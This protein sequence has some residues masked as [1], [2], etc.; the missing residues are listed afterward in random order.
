VT[1]PHRDH[2][3][4]RKE[5]DRVSE[6][7]YAALTPDVILDAVET[8]GRR[9][10]GALQALNSYENRVYRV[11]LEDDKPVAAKFY[12]PARWS[13]AAIREE[14]GFALELAAQEIPVVAPL[15]RDGET[16]FTHAG[17]RFALFPWQPG[18]VSE[19]NSREEREVLGRYLGRLHRVGRARRFEHRPALTVESFGRESADYL[20]RNN[21]LPDY[22]AGSY[23]TLADDLLE[24]IANRF[25]AVAAPTLRLHGDCHLSNLL[26]TD[27]SPHLVDLDDCRTGPA[28]QDLWM[29]LSGTHAEREMQ[30]GQVLAGYT[31]FMEFDP[32]EL[33]LIEPLR[34]LRLMHYSAWLARRWDDPAFPVNFPWFNTKRYWEEQ[35]QYLREQLAALDEP[36]LSWRP[37]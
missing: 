21:F 28:V 6:H 27:G 7:P 37:D 11:E 22:L 25:E 4:L 23:R 32:A 8:F 17:F 33:V 9:C 15:A 5:N 18:R 31:R 34:T 16:L 26:W 1:A 36:S 10:T 35:L 30:L 20:L 19:L 13:D 12:R 24:R 29:L 3:A 14:H 2:S